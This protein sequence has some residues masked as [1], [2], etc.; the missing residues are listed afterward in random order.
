MT[1][2]VPGAPGQYKAQITAEELLKLQ[3]GEQFTI[4]M[5]RDD[6]PII[7]GTPFSK[8]AVL[9]DALANSLCP[10]IDDPTPAEAINALLSLVKNRAPAGTNSTSKKSD[11]DDF[12]TN[13]WIK[14]YSGDESIRLIDGVMSH[15]VDV[16]AD[17]FD[18]NYGVQTAI[19]STGYMLR[20][21]YM[22]KWYGWRWV[23]PPLTPGAE[24]VT[25]EEFDGSWVYTKVVDLGSLPNSAS[26]YVHFSSEATKAIR[27]IGQTGNGDTLPLF[28][29]NGEVKIYA[30]KS[31]IHVKTDFNA[32]NITATAQ[33]WYIK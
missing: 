19:T 21:K 12:R 14:F 5:T 27:C 32:S 8:A 7:E 9:P 6:Q 20:R 3:N 28:T 1:D 13:G 26:K 4:T 2:R 16:R 24:Y 10:D 31:S 15:A 30:S 17:F 22:K 18:E 23:N 11:I 33:V 29:D 25:A